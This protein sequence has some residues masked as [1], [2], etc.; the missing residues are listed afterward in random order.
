MD[1]YTPLIPG[2]ILTYVSA[3]ESQGLR[4]DLF[5]FQQKTGYSRSHFQHLID[6]G[7]VTINGVV[8]TKSS[9]IVKANDTVVLTIPLPVARP[10]TKEAVG[11]LDVSIVYEN[12]HFLVVNKPPF[13]SVHA[14]SAG[15]TELTLVDWLVAHV[16]GIKAVGSDD[17]PGIV[18]R[19]D[20]D[21]SGLLIVA[22][23]AY[24]HAKLSDLFKDREMHKTYYAIVQGHTPKAGFIDAN[25]VRH[26]LHP[27][28][29]THS[30][31]QGRQALTRY[32]AKEFLTD[33]TWV[34]AKPVTGRTH[35]IRVHLASIGHPLIGDAVYHTKSPL[36][37]R[38]ALHAYRLTFTFE[39]QDFDFTQEP[40]QDFLE[41]VEK[42]RATA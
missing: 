1:S 18:H 34:E 25:I 41:L 4:L 37:N 3:P 5:L 12:E 35:Q 8:A 26:P 21:T 33:A 28:K 38:Q 29:M 20:K 14:P 22:K 11:H 15:N 36:I 7:A 24:S 9:V 17:R 40:P 39:G 31:A 2:S 23:N 10:Q 30:K 13:L 27:T 32:T 6:A 42:L 16:N 19:L